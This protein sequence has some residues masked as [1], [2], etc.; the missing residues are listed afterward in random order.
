MTFLDKIY[1]LNLWRFGNFKVKEFEVIKKT[2]KTV[3]I[4]MY[5][6]DEDDGGFSDSR[7]TLRSR[8][9]AFFDNLE[10]ANR[11]AENVITERLRYEETR[12][13]ELRERLQE[14]CRH[15]TITSPMNGG[16]CIRCDFKVPNPED[17]CNGG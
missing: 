9:Y 11:A 1:R 7:Y 4:R 3:V 16:K 13:Q 14:V 8:E 17:Y 6:N 15:R 10:D 12:V 5:H 2:E